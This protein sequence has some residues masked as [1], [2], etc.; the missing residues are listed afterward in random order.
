MSKTITSGSVVFMDVTD[1]RRLD[2][3]ITSNLPTVQIK[4]INVNPNT[5]T[6]D[7]TSTPLVL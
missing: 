4:N 6:P 1:N 5:Y 2:V 7:W 3:Y